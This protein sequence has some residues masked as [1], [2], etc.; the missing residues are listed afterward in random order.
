MVTRIVKMEFRAECI[1]AFLEMFEAKKEAIIAQPGCMD[2]EM[3][4][5][6]HNPAIIFTYSHWKNE[7]A[8]NAYRGTELFGVVWK[9]TKSY[10]SGKASAW[11]T[12][13]LH[14]LSQ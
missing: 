8:L 12:T 6:I 4:Q 14:K 3:L 10:F 13:S 9:E 2:L 7:A 5:D 11:S 1:D